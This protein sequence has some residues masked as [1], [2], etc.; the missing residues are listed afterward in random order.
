MK[1]KTVII[2][3][4]VLVASVTAVAIKMSS[5][6]KNYTKPSAIVGDFLLKNVSLDSVNTISINDGKKSVDLT[7]KDGKWLVPARDNFPAAVKDVNTLTD[8]AF[9][10]KVQEVQE[11]IGPGHYP[12]LGL[13]PAGEGV[14]PEETGKTVSFKD[15]SGKEIGSLVVGRTQEKKPDGMFSMSGP[16]PSPQWIKVGGDNAVYKAATGFS[17]LDGDPKLWLDKEKFFKVEKHKSITVT[18]PTPEESW[19]IVREKEGG[20]LKLDAPKPGEEF[21]AGK[22]SGQGSV[23][24]YI[25]FDDILPAAEKDKAALDKPTHTAV[26]ET[27]DGLTYTVKVGAKVPPPPP[28]TG[29]DTSTPPESHYVSFTV[30]G[31]L[32]ET[33]PPYA[34]PA[35]T[36][37]A[38]PAA[39]AKEEDKKKYEEAKKAHET[40]MKTWEDGKKASETT[41]QETLK[42]KKEKL[43]AEQALQTRIFVVPKGTLEPIM[44]KRSDFM[45][46]KPA[47]PPAADGSTPAT[48]GAA[49]ASTPKVTP[50]PAIP[51]KPGAKIEATTPPIEVTLPGKEAPKEAPKVTPPPAPEPKAEDKKETP[52]KP[53]D[54]K[55]T[56]KKPK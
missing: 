43:A 41:F 11:K 22:A 9:A 49:A 37:P 17:K 26:I 42:T 30:E 52:A 10:L 6:G 15:A 47:T 44:K 45:K 4:G 27:F 20:D 40:A 38:A 39:D 34:T 21:D 29:T 23:F 18:G 3:G 14:K 25:S 12:R 51:P 5:D 36:P 19:K 7:L 2:L 56:K 24:S 35:P 28:A 13:A 32:D 55:E 46:D 53:E 1:T 54:K 50:M 8:N 48:P 33:A 16:E 31:K